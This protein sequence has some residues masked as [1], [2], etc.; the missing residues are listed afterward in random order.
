MRTEARFTLTPALAHPMGEGESFAGYLVSRVTEFI[1]RLFVRQHTT[2]A[3]PSPIGW[4]RV[5]VRVG[6]THFTDC[7]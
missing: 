6:R 2:I 3:V 7:P 5:R 4:E 1:G